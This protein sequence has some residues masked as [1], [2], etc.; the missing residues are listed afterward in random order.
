VTTVPRYTSRDLEL[1]P[2]P[3]DGTR[4]EIIDG[5]L[6]VSKQPDYH[7]QYACTQAASALAIWSE[8]TEAGLTLVA[9]GLI[10]SPDQD[11]APDL[12][13]I[14]HERLAQGADRAG[15]L[16]IAPEVVVE[17]LSYGSV[18]ERRD[19]ELK[20]A[21]YSRQGV[22]E[23]WIIDWRFRTVQVFRRRGTVLEL[24]AT[25][26]REDVLTS[27]LLPGFACPITRF[28]VPSGM[29]SPDPSTFED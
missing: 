28:W 24:E 25:L 26:E 21:L 20:R 6:H 5:D 14:S 9:P 12:V 3:I 2:D 17:V 22:R 1:L 16:R 11:V 15:H 7:H 8:P 13:W 10:F 4:Y 29:P 23:Y 27:P 18:N 19:R